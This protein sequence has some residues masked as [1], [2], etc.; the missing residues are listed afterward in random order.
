MSVCEYEPAQKLV[1]SCSPLT[2]VGYP[3]DD[4]HDNDAALLPHLQRMLIHV[5]CV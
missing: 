2:R 1:L 3:C 5:W 4:H